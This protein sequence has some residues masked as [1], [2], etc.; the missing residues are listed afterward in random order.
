MNYQFLL[1]MLPLSFS[2]LS[3]AINSGMV[4]A[5]VN[6]LT[7]SIMLGVLG[8]AIMKAET[9]VGHIDVSPLDHLSLYG[10][11]TVVVI[12]F[13]VSLYSL[14]YFRHQESRRDDFQI[15]NVRK[16]YRL[17]GLLVASMLFACISADLG[18]TWMALEATTLIVSLSLGVFKR[19]ANLESAW[20]YLIVC[21][22]GLILSLMGIAILLVSIGGPL[23]TETSLNFS[24]FYGEGITFNP[25]LVKAAFIF[26]LVGLGTKMAIVPMHAWLPDAIQK[27]ETPLAILLTCALKQ[28]AFIFLLRLKFIVDYALGSQTYSASLLIFFGLLSVLASAIFMINQHDLK[29]LLAMSS[30]E[31]MG[32]A[33]IA[34]GLPYK[35]AVIVA[36]IFLFLQALVKASMFFLAGN[37]ELV[38]G[39]SD[40]SR[41]GNTA[42]Y[43]PTASSLLMLAM[44][45]TNGLPPFGLFLTKFTIIKYL[46]DYNP[47]LSLLLLMAT[48]L[49]FGA[50][51]YSFGRMLFYPPIYE[52]DLEESD[53]RSQFMFFA[54]FPVVLALSLASISFIFYGYIYDF[55]GA[56]L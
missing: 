12:S 13:L 37:I 36:L 31:A 2:L 22:V 40:F 39:S 34:I 30:V 54:K 20:N 5:I 9:H 41:I 4:L 38:Y 53:Y 51:V 15:E 44:L 28:V 27:S 42:K 35:E 14:A 19:D 1:F 21:S 50:F 11:T 43:L 49:V 29:R 23:H 16:F 47:W 46:T 18:W 55:L 24:S 6:I 52:H 56:S 33:L 3:F 32:L 7:N 10:I 25:I 48:V 45:A 8:S 17:S 26:I